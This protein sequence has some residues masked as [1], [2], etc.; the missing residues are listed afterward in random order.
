MNK[1][2]SLAQDRCLTCIQQSGQDCGA[3]QVENDQTFL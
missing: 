2:G 1:R 3:L